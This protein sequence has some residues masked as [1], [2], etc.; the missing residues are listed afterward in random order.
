MS[1][2]T[3]RQALCSAGAAALAPSVAVGSEPSALSE[4]MAGTAVPG[5]AAIV[6]RNFRAE[7]EIVA[8]VRR[9]GSS[10]PVR[11]GDR[12]YLGS[13]AKAMTATLIAV[14]AEEGD[15]SWQARLEDMLP[16]LASEMHSEYRDLTLPDLLS[17]RS[18]ISPDMV[19]FD[20]LVSFFNDP[21]PLSDQRR[22]YIAA[23]LALPPTGAKRAEHLYS[24][25]NYY[26]AAAI[27]ERATG[28]EY[29]DLMQAH[30]F[31]PL[32]MRS[33]SREPIGGA[34]EPI[35][36]V[37]G[38]QAD[39]FG[40]ANSDLEPPMGAPSHG[41]IRLS[42]RDWSRFCIDQMYGEQ[43]L[44]RLL[45][46]ESY[47]FLHAAQGDTRY[48]LGWYTQASVHGRRGPALYHSGSD[49]N[50]M[51]EAVLFPR[52]GDG[53]LVVANSAYGMDGNT[54]TAAVVRSVVAT[55]S[56]GV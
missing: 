21:A 3:R 49:G 53:V 36:H 14:L 22:R 32:G 43:G 16:E 8:G 34:D 1:L 47:R 13:D 7:R 2:F 35:G 38:R 27:A 46:G 45:R 54:A 28:R 11:R 31:R 24:N 12:W 5:M 6:I 40:T 23:A 56:E 18:G 44:G 41:G 37:G 19:S 30:V 9:L 4:A 20:L 39:R 29:E 42:L 15:L 25:T 10:D 26:I 33:V 17:H 55:M 51:A 50:W 48:A 52:W